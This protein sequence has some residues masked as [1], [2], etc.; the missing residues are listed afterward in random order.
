MKKKILFIGDAVTPTGFSRV[1][2]SIIENLDSERFEVHHLGINYYGDPHDFKHKIYPASIRGDIYGVNRIKEFKVLAPDVIFILNDLWMTDKYLAEIKGVWGSQPPKVVV[3]IPV[4][5]SHFDPDWFKNFDVVSQ[6]VAYSQFG[7]DVL[8]KAAPKTID[9]KIVPH[10]V[11]TKIFYPL[12]EGRREIKAQLYPP[13]DEFLDSFIVLNAHRN[14]PRKRIDIALHGFALFA[15][16]K[17]AN[18]KY[19]HHAGITDVGWNA[20]RLA[21]HYGMDKRIILTNLEQQVQRV[22]DDRLNMIYNA[23]DVGIN[24]SLGE[25]WGLP[26][27]EHAATG[28]VQVVPGNSTSQELFQDCGIIIPPKLEMVLER[29][30]TIGSICS[31][32]DV[33]TALQTLYDSPELTKELSEKCLKKF[34]S[35]QYSWKVIARQWE[36]IFDEVTKE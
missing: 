21:K 9:F 15:E 25:G 28:A 26:N 22:S 10:G 11:T 2:H 3:Y 4:D 20:L 12:K 19:Y 5:A 31:P 17:P 16:G 14:Q 33:A 36:D 8:K 32:E 18:V 34:T 13:K 6:A 27:V 35:E 1:N 23:C 30:N 7:Y 29:I 24:T